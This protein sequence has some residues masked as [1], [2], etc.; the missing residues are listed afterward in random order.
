MRASGQQRAL[1]TIEQRGRGV[2][3]GALEVKLGGAAARIEE[4]GEP[5]FVVRVKAAHLL[6]HFGRKGGEVRR[7]HATE[8]QP[9]TVLVGRTKEVDVRRQLGGR[10]AR[11]GTDA[12][13]RVGEPV[14]I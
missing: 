10:I 1:E 13:Q 3:R 14:A 7:E 8:A 9:T 11:A 4:A 2:A 12:S 6:L 5:G